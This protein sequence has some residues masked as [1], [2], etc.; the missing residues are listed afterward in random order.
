MT[1]TCKIL[2]KYRYFISFMQITR[3]SRNVLLGIIYLEQQKYST[4]YNLLLIALFHFVQLRTRYKNTTRVVTIGLIF[5]DMLNFEQ[6]F[7]HINV[8]KKNISEGVTLKKTVSIWLEILNTRHCY[9]IKQSICCDN[10][11]NFHLH[12][13]IFE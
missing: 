1:R 10:N 12:I 11:T 4:R 2:L 5:E 8:K 13:S 6:F 3:N 9:L 7:L